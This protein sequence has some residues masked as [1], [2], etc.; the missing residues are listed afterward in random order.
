MSFMRDSDLLT[1]IHAQ[2]QLDD[3]R[4]SRPCSISDSFAISK[5]TKMT[6]T[7][8][9]RYRIQDSQATAGTIVIL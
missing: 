5:I 6:K 8:P 1:S 9:T 4:C 2:A 3:S 7:Q